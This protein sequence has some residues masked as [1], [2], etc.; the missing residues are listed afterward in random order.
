M[1]KY[2]LINNYMIAFFN[3][4]WI[5]DNK[6]NY[7][8]S[9]NDDVIYLNY[10]ESEKEKKYKL[11][12]LSELKELKDFKEFDNEIISNISKER[13]IKGIIGKDFLSKHSFIINQHCIG[14]GDINKIIGRINNYLFNTYDNDQPVEL[15][16][17]ISKNN[18]LGLINANGSDVKVFFDLGC[19]ENNIRRDFFRQ[20]E[21]LID[22][23]NDNLNFK[24]YLEPIRLFAR[25]NDSKEYIGINDKKCDAIVSI[26]NKESDLIFKDYI[27]FDYKNK[28]IYIK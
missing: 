14:F 27:A 16:A 15:N 5:I 25:E 28:K 24:E 21:L 7:T 20:N 8:Y 3:G 11:K 4:D 1:H 26:F 10:Y 6:Y 19:S 18:L 12:K 9:F 2:R 23:D 13:P 17:I 22:Y